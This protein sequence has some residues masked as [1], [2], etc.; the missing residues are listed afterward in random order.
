[1]LMTVPEYNDKYGDVFI[2][3]RHIVMPL[4]IIE[5]LLRFYASGAL[6]QYAGWKGKLKYAVTPYAIIDLVSILPYLLVYFAGMPNSSALRS[7]RLLRIFRLFRVKKYAIFAQSMKRIFNNIKEEIAV[8]LL[9]TVI[10]IIILSFVIFQ[11]EHEAQPEIFTNI[12]QTM[13]WS[14]ATLTTVGYGDMYPITAAGKFITA[15]ITILGIA[16]IAIPGSLFASEFISEISERKKKESNTQI[17][18]KCASENIEIYLEPIVETDRKELSFSKLS[19]C[20][21]CGFSWLENNDLSITAGTI[22]SSI[23]N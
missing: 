22:S 11:I 3:I 5:Y 9:Y 21:N 16:F 1:M 2:L 10:I 4:F 14:V 7:L 13:W 6:E 18:P 17:C 15:L 23:K 19:V 8:L 20:K 12:F